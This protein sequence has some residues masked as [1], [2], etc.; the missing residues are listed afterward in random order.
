MVNYKDDL[1]ACQAFFKLGGKTFAQTCQVKTKPGR[2]RAAS[3]LDFDLAGFLPA[4]SGLVV[5]FIS[6]TFHL[7]GGMAH[8]FSS[9]YLSPN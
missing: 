9:V 8:Y 6:C 7:V 2:S 5:E 3:K 1:F 4:R